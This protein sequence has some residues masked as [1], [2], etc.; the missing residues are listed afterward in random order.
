M[1]SRSHRNGPQARHQHASTSGGNGRVRTGGSMSLP[2][3]FLPGAFDLSVLIC[4]GNGND[5][6]P[7][8]LTGH[9]TSLCFWNHR[10][11]QYLYHTG[12]A[13]VALS[14]FCLPSSHLF[15]LGWEIL[16]RRTWYCGK[17]SEVI[18]HIWESPTRLVRS[19]FGF[20]HEDNAHPTSQKWGDVAVTFDGYLEITNTV[21]HHPRS[22]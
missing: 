15:K 12:L 8:I 22:E 6:C 3:R 10:C 17:G 18:W 9:N 19:G 11:T 14:R 1:H 5:A 21:D 7:P 16:E 4:E 2:T 20:S 13:P